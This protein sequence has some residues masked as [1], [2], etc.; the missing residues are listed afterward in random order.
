MAAVNKELLDLNHINSYIS[1]HHRLQTTVHMHYGT[2][3]YAPLCT[4]NK[5]VLI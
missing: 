2:S 1:C 5:L 3:T 4:N